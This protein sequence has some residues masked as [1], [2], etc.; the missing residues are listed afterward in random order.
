MAERVRGT[1]KR[2]DPVKGYGFIRC[3]DGRDVFV[4]RSAVEHL[5]FPYL[6]EGEQIEFE[7]EVGP[8]GA[9]AVNIRRVTA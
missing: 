5:D 9:N 4:H 6:S 3:E 1:V 2:F 7:T 8:N